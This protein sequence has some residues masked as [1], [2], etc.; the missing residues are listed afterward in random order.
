M[1]KAIIGKKLGMSQ[2]F[3]EDGTVI[4]VTVVEAGPCEITQ[5]KTE[6]K[7]GYHAVQVAFG[8]VKV[9]K[10]TK[11]LGGIFKK[12]NL[13]PKKYLREL[14]LEGDYQVGSKITCD[15]FN[16]G[17]IVDVTGI[18]KGHGYTGTIQRWNAHRLK[19]TH[20]VG[21]VHRQVGSMGANTW[22]A[23]VFPGKKMPGHY[24]VDQVTIQN[25][26]VARIDTD[27]N[28]LLIKGAI[29]G[30]NGGLVNVHEAVKR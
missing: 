21:P 14:D 10:V 3:A 28:L 17:D 8:V 18:S 16:V 4:P 5:I 30:P 25:L 1:K 27:K 19:M 9:A 15:I 23:R 22:P 7:E 11:P 24:G 6:E 20:G 29:P 26:Q 2:I 12:A 13:E